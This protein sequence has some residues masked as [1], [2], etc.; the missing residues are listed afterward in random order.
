MTTLEITG[1]VDAP[2]VVVL[3]GISSSRHVTATAANPSPGWWNEFV[4]P[5]RAIDTLEFR[6]ASIDYDALSTHEQASALIDALRGENITRLHAVV[7]A[8]YGGM[9]A[10]ALAELYPSL[11]ERLIVIGAAHESTP[12]ATAQRSL[13]RK[14]VEL[15]LRSGLELEALGIARGMAVTTYSTPGDLESRFDFDDPIEREREIERFLTLTGAQFTSRCAPERFLD[16]SRSLDHHYVNAS[17]ITCPT[18]IIGVLE[19]FLVPP[20]QLTELASRIAGPC[21]LSLLSSIYGHDAFLED[22]SLIAP[23]VKR[24]LA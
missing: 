22:Q 17:S 5:G 21:E 19:D 9:V 8:S 18:T 13:Q 6:I 7:G 2:V 4:G 1:A 24:A 14:V 23:I 10:L 16:L 12:S 15:G 11:T 3:G 20:S